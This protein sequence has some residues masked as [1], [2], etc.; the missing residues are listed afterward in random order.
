[1]GGDGRWETRAIDGGWECQLGA[2]T[3]GHGPIWHMDI[4]TYLHQTPDTSSKLLAGAFLAGAWG[5]GSHPLA[6][7]K[8]GRGKAAGRRAPPPRSRAQ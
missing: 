8:T 7:T 2:S 6:K 1:M 5:L 4:Y 3:T